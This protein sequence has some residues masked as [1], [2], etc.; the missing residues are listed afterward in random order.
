MDKY[1]ERFKAP[2][3][4]SED[5]NDDDSSGGYST[6]SSEPRDDIGEIS[7]EGMARYLGRDTSSIES[8]S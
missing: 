1:Y 7:E 5:D 8:I 2:T 6:R 3:S 4:I